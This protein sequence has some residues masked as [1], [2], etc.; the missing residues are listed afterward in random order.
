MDKELKH[1]KSVNENLKLMV[2]D[3]K[4]RQDGMKR[5]VGK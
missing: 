4:M 1:L 2:E 5:E 3:L